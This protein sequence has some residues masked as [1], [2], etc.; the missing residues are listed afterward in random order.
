MKE[1][2][3]ITLEG[4]GWV[5][6]ERLHQASERAI[7]GAVLGSFNLTTLYLIQ[8]DL[9][10]ALEYSK[11]GLDL[12]ANSSKKYPG[13]LA[14]T[15]NNSVLWQRGQKAGTLEAE[16]P[17]PEQAAELEPEFQFVGYLVRFFACELLQGQ[18][19]YQRVIDWARECLEGDRYQADSALDHL[20]LGTAILRLHEQAGTRARPPALA[21]KHLD[22]AAEGLER[23][24]NRHHLPRAMLTRADWHRLNGDPEEAQTN[25]DNAMLPSLMSG[26]RLY[27]ADCHLAHARLHLDRREPEQAR[28]RLE[29]VRTLVDKNHYHR[30]DEKIAECENELSR[31]DGVSPISAA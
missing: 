7:Q 24:G 31:L 26:M 27:Q 9:D 22:Q 19:Q 18:H 3:E 16:P 11:I 5:Q 14:R 23:V 8:G 2:Q 15:I 25:L 17:P 1:G 20:T 28:T 4:I 10:Q 6:G 12:A 29:A 30:L 21:K 13:Y